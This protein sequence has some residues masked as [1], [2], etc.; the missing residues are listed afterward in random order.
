MTA[1]AFGVL[2]RELVER[3][4]SERHALTMFALSASF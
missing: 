4:L 2:V 3:G 1:P